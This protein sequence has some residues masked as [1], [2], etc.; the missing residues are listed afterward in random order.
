MARYMKMVL[1]RLAL[2]GDRRLLGFY[3]T[4]DYAE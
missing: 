3:G 1:A 4:H 2:A